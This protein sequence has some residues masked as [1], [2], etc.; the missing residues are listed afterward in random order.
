MSI[1]SDSKTKAEPDAA[2]I[3]AESAATDASLGE[4]NSYCVSSPENPLKRNLVVSIRASLNDLCLS[5]SKGLWTPSH[6]ALKSM[7]QCAP[8][9]LPDTPVAPTEGAQ[10]SLFLV[11][12]YCRADLRAQ[13][14]EVHLPLWRG[15]PPGRPA[16][17]QLP[18]WKAAWGSILKRNVMKNDFKNTIM[19]SH[20]L[21]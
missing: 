18:A 1:R 9:A 2:A 21:P 6:E 7:L 8:C 10:E 20:E 5:K 4:G 11:L 15:R 16:H 13:A 17:P 3:L 19:L 14:E 12:L